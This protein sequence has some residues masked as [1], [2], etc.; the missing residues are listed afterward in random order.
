MK[1]VCEIDVACLV[2]MQR[3]F[4]GRFALEVQLHCPKQTRID[5]GDRLLVEFVPG[6]ED[7]VELEGYGNR[8]VER[9]SPVNLLFD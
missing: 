1:A 9:L 8:Y 3:D 7:P 6:P 4:H 2:M 5:V